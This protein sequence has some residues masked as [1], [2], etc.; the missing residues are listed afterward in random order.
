MG[1]VPGSVGPPPYLVAS[2][3]NTIVVAAFSVSSTPLPRTATASQNVRPRGFSRSFR[4]S[5]GS[6]LGR[7]R[8][9]YWNTIGISS[10]S[11]SL[12]SRFCRRFSRLSRLASSTGSWLSDTKT[13][14]SAPFS[15]MRRVAL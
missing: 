12:A 9:L 11:I 2:E 7:S 14:Q 8:L 10:G 1:S 15:T 6:A 13:T 3:R 4:I 5:M